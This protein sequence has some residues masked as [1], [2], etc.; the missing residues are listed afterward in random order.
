[1]LCI[2]AL[3]SHDCCIVYIDNFK[4]MIVLLEYMNCF[5]FVLASCLLAM[6]D[7]GLALNQLL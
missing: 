5:P 2:Y 3:S 4:I 7:S 1:M 6:N